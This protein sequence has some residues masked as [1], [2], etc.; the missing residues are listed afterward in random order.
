MTT[1][2]PEQLP[3]PAAAFEPPDDEPS[4]ENAII[5]WAKAIVFG[6]G[7][8][9][10]DMLDEGRRGARDAMEHGWDRFDAKTKH[11]RK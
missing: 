1:P 10:K 4:E 8:T 3:P 6:I 2:D 9:A 7:D 5:G 11:R